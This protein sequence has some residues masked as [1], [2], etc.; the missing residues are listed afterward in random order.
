MNLAR[1][2]LRPLIEGE[3]SVH[4]RLHES[5]TKKIKPNS[6]ILQMQSEH[7]SEL[8]YSP[9]RH[10]ERQR[11]RSRTIP[12][13]H[14][15]SKETDQPRLTPL[16]KK[17]PLN[18]YN[19]P[20]K[21]KLKR[22]PYS[23]ALNTELTSLTQQKRNQFLSEIKRKENPTSSSLILPKLDSAIQLNE[24]PEEAEE[25]NITEPKYKQKKPLK[26]KQQLMRQATRDASNKDRLAESMNTSLVK[27][28]ETATGTNL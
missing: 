5:K 11:S 9:E 25:I 2:R 26:P 23:N 10:Q 8:K 1:V 7:L 20:S 24:H 3:K 15:E 22:K 27:N 28:L 16:E 21:L 17:M 4:D 19:V 14:E 6:V 18:Y 13:Q 12:H